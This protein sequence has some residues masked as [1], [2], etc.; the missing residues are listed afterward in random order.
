MTQKRSYRDG[1]LLETVCAKC[2][3]LERAYSPD[4]SMLDRMS[5]EGGS[6]CLSC[7]LKLRHKTKI[8]NTKE[9]DPHLLE[10]GRGCR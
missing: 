10:N 8:E 6:L 1:F 5:E 3:K 4:P 7:R 9:T 2:G